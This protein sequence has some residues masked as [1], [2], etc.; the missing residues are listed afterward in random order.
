MKQFYLFT[1]GIQ[2]EGTKN[3]M[4]NDKFSKKKTKK[5]YCG[6]TSTHNTNDLEE[7]LKPIGYDLVD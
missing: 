7:D 5:I 2:I 4:E 1:G 3:K 6:N